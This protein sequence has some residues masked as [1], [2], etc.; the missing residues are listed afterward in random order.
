MKNAHRNITYSA[1][2]YILPLI[3]SLAT[4]P[5]MIKYM[6]VDIYGLYIICVSLIGFMVFVY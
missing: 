4:I 3:I 1:L 5:L 6:G 2:G